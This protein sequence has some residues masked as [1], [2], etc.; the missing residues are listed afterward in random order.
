MSDDKA[1][2]KT[3]ILVTKEKS[4]PSA[5]SNSVLNLVQSIK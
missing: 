5:N 3:D 1:A 4:S 2:S